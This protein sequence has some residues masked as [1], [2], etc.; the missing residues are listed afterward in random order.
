MV[1]VHTIHAS[2]TQKKYQQRNRLNESK[3]LQACI[4]EIVCECLSVEFRFYGNGYVTSAT[5]TICTTS[6]I[7]TS[8][9]CLN[10]VPSMLWHLSPIYIHIHYYMHRGK[11]Y[12]Y[13]FVHWSCSTMSW[14][15]I[16]QITPKWRRPTPLLFILIRAQ[17]ECSWI[18]TIKK[19]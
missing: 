16:T 4:R 12:I 11:S 13:I 3:S 5:M 6:K 2:I 15:V 7:H 19:N 9:L 18:C 14:K 1:D 10:G 17:N 8:L